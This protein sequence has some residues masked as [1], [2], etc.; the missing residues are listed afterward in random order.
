MKRKV[1]QGKK[2]FCTE[3]GSALDDFWLVHKSEEYAELLKHHFECQRTGKFKGSMCS[4]LFI[5]DDGTSNTRRRKTKLSPKK[6][7]DLKGSILRKIDEE[8]TRRS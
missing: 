2:S 5:A 4:R 6:L 8:Q 1:Q 7:A 3:C